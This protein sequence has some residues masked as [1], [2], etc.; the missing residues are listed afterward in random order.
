MDL[1]AIERVIFRKSTPADLEVVLRH[2]ERIFTEM[3]TPRSAA[4][5]ADSRNFFGDAM[6]NGLYHGWLAEEADSVV[7]GVGIIL[8]RYQPGPSQ[9]G[10]FRPFVV[11]VWT[12]PDNR[13]RG[14]GRQ[15]MELAIEWS[16]TQGFTNLFLH[17]TDDGRRL[18][19][20]LGFQA[21]NEMK[22]RLDG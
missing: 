9:K 7:G 17:A 15:L 19:E 20:Q 18:Y 6:R 12:E 13:R 2:R 22:L 1:S 11:N 21:T 14:I 3:G 5:Q 4:D 16:R 10:E 8:L